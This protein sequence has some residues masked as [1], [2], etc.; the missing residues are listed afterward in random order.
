MRLAGLT[1]LIRLCR[2]TGLM[3]LMRLKR[4]SCSPVLPEV[5]QV[6]G[7]A[8]DTK[9]RACQACSTGNTWLV[10]DIV[11]CC[12]HANPYHF[13]RESTAGCERFKACYVLNRV[14]KL[15][16]GRPC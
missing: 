10:H 13:M 15:E 6:A 16:K 4:L 3:R 14:R 8:A 2:L 1:G 9:E 7:P 5:G 12:L 11:V